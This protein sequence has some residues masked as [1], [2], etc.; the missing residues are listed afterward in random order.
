LNKTSPAGICPVC[1]KEYAQLGRH[2]KRIHPGFKVQNPPAFKLMSIEINVMGTNEYGAPT[3][4]PQG[5]FVSD[6]SGTAIEHATN[7]LNGLPAFLEMYGGTQ[8]VTAE[9]VDDG[10]KEGDDK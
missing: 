10:A 8:F 7:W 5:G 1:N 2:M 3:Q 9:D 6:V 4:G